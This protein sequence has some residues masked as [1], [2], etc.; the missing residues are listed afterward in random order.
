MIGNYHPLP[1][2]SLNFKRETRAMNTF[3]M[4]DNWTVEYFEPNI[5]GFE[6][7]PSIRDVP[8][9][10][11]WHCERRFAEAGFYGWLQRR[12]ELAPTEQCVRYLIQIENAP[13]DTKVYVN[14]HHL[15]D[16]EGDV[17]RIDVTDVVS[18]GKNRLSLRVNCST[19]IR[20]QFES[21]V[22]LKV[23]CT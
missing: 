13:S 16:C 20:S 11:E 22:L 23:P 18:L 6:M 19:E 21:V 8:R 1:N 7:A 10:T 2:P 15:A 5:D 9:L 12:F 17:V 14:D 4:N 3:P